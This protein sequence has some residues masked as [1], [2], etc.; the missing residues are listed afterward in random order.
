MITPLQQTDRM[1]LEPFLSVFETVIFSA[2]RRTG[3]RT[4]GP[5]YLKRLWR[6]VSIQVAQHLG[7]DSHPFI[8]LNA[9]RLCAAVAMEAANNISGN[10]SWK[11]ERNTIEVCWKLVIALEE[12]HDFDRLLLIRI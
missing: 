9:F 12:Y 8:V 3:H 11:A 4:V 10:S 7:H 6:L 2:A 1:Q 5:K